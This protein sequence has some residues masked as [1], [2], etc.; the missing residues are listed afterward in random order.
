M[1]IFSPYRNESVQ[2]HFIFSISRVISLLVQLAHLNCSTPPLL[3][4]LLLQ[5]PTTPDPA[6]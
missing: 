5:Q 2:V 3:V 6:S 1:Y 4:H